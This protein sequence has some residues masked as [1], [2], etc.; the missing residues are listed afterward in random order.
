[1]VSE[2]KSR[3]C[4]INIVLKSVVTCKEHLRNDPETVTVLLW[5]SL[6]IQQ[7]QVVVLLLDCATIGYR[8]ESTCL[9]T[10]PWAFKSVQVKL[11]QTRSG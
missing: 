5:S 3:G 7:N 4:E 2:S 1:M 6:Y 8:C 11:L 10:P 9:N